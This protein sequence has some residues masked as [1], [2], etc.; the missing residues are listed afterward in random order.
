MSQL[1][2]NPATA[3]GQ[4][5]TGT[6]TAAPF[7][8]YRAGETIDG[9][10]AALTD[11]KH[12]AALYRFANAEF[13]IRAPASVTTYRVEYGRLVASINDGNAAEVFVVDGAE[14]FTRA[15]GDGAVR[16][17]TLT[18]LV[19]LRITDVNGTVDGG[20][21]FKMWVRGF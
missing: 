10:M 9:P 7:R 6:E 14:W 20:E 4:Q 17:P 2:N 8:S 13:L 11:R 21:T 18:D 12:F 5:R 16:F 3:H 1:N 15:A 19:G